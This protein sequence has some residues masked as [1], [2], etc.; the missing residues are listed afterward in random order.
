[1]NLF[2]ILS[3]SYFQKFS[4]LFLLISFIF[5]FGLKFDY[6]QFRF[7]ILLLLFPC[8]FKIYKDINLKKYNFIIF[9]TSLSFFL[10]LHTGVKYLL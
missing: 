9:F 1:M 8:V 4:I 6:F 3:A 5:L 2:N 7:L 10:F